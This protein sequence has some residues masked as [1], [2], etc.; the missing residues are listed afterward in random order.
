MRSA[1]IGAVSLVLLCGAAAAQGQPAG[2]PTKK[3]ARPPASRPADRQATERRRGPWRIGDVVDFEAP[4]LEG[5]K[6]RLA[7]L[8][9]KVVVVDFWSIRCPWSRGYDDRLKALFEDYSKK[10][11]VFL[12]L[13]PNNTEVARSGKDPYA[14]IRKYVRRAKIPFT[15]G[16]DRNG[17]I[18]RRFG[19]RT[20]PHAFVID[21]KGRLV[22]AGGIDDDFQFRK[23]REGE[24]P[25]PWLRNALDAVLA[26]KKVEPAV[27]QPFGCSIKYPKGRRKAPRKEKPASRPERKA[28]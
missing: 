24:E 12:A 26:G 11:V 13:N 16:I 2:K 5:K 25:T 4:T 18:A 22:Y 15:V 27:T 6:V 8:R 17:A 20:T 28:G 3:T 21:P 19:A 1:W 7:D 23:S 14:A 9:G 10:G